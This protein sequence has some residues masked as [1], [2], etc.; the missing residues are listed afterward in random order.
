MHHIKGAFYQ[1]QPSGSVVPRITVG[2]F[3]PDV[4]SAQPHVLSRTLVELQAAGNMIK[5]GVFM[6]QRRGNKE[7]LSN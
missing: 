6:Q 2:T 7:T 3:S 1:F 5:S 4:N